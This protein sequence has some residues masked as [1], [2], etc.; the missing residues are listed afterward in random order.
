[1]SKLTAKEVAKRF[2]TVP[3]SSLQKAGW[4][5][6][7]NDPVMQARL[8]ENIRRN[9]Q[10]ENILVRDIEDGKREVINGNHRLD[11]LLTLGYEHVM[12]CDLTPM[13]LDHAKRLA[14]ETNETRFN[15]DPLLLAQ[16]VVD[17]FD[18]F[19]D[20]AD[21]APFT[22]DQLTEFSETLDFD[23][24]SHNEPEEDEASKGPRTQTVLSVG[25][26]DFK[27]VKLELSAAC[28]DRFIG[29]VQRLENLLGSPSA[30]A[31]IEAIC[32]I[33][34]SLTDDQLRVDAGKSA[35]SSKKPA[36]SAKKN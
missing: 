16:I 15:S 1:M 34:E 4:N 25:G 23:S 6:K 12:V 11:A 13:T 27:T 10:V 33:F 29:L 35:K 26:L 36:K 14:L 24:G 32:K 31:P 30:N 18:N 20:F 9:G 17:T 19:D 7:T 5:Y 3:I 22:G 8:V 2:K 21:T 28:A